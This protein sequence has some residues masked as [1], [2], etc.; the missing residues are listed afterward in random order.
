MKKHDSKPRRLP[1]I[2]NRAG[3]LEVGSRFHAVAVPAD[4][5]QNPTQTFN[6]FTVDLEQMAN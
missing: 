3:G 6:A 4:L 2:N 1:V 5:A